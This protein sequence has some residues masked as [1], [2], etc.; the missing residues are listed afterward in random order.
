M[1]L[2]FKPVSADSHVVEPPDLWLKRIDRRYLDRA[3]HGVEDQEQDYFFCPEAR[4]L[5]GGK[6]RV[7]MTSSVDKKDEE[8][9]AIGRFADILPGAYDPLARLVDQDRDGIE[10]EVL[11]TTF[12]L[13]MYTI[14]D[15]E[16]QLACMQAFNDWLANFCQ[17][18]PGR[19]Y[20]A[21]MIPTGP[22]DNAVEEMTRCA[23]TGVLRTAQISI[24]Q[25]GDHGYD[26]P[27]WDPLWSASVDLDM[28]ISL[29]VGGSKHLFG[30]THS[31]LTDF[32]LGFTPV[33]YAITGMIFAGV[34]DRF[35]RLR[36]ISVE[37]DA[38]WPVPVLE[39]MDYRFERDK[40]WAGS[41]GITSGRKPSD[42]FHDHVFCT[43]MR[44][45]TAVKNRDIVGVNNIM[46]GSD[47][48]HFDGTW[49]H[50]VDILEGHFDG[51]SVEDQRRIA[52]QNVID[53]YHLPLDR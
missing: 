49:P 46:W 7:G 37:N 21:A 34:F 24:G 4:V 51:V 6:N 14:D 42:I 10:A 28:P 35:P 32:S 30:F 22:V 9:S 53:L 2:G 13:C 39:R 52:R 38:S 40:G 31:L 48:P 43:F 41:G 36:V 23:R 16:F 5:P 33:M 3:P 19:F 20:G 29:H 8:I 45:R 11:Y 27:E 26:S 18:A 17:S 1:T 25:D 50:S 44:D 15:L 47:F 12:G